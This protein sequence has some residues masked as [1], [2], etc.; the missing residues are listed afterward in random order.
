ACGVRPSGSWMQSFVDRCEELLGEMSPRELAGLPV[1]LARL[2]AHPGRS[3]LG[4]YLDV[5][6]EREAEFSQA[7]VSEAVRAVASLDRPFLLAW[8]Q[9]AMLRRQEQERERQQQQQQARA[10]AAAAAAAEGTEAAHAGKHQQQH[11]QQQLE[12]EEEQQEEPQQRSPAA[13]DALASVD[14]MLSLPYDNYAV[15]ESGGDVVQSEE[16][17]DVVPVLPP[18]HPKQLSMEESAQKTPDQPG[19]GDQGSS[20][21]RNSSSLP[22]LQPSPSAV[23]AVRPIELEVDSPSD[24][25]EEELRKAGSHNS[26]PEGASKASAAP[27]SVT[28]ALSSSSSSAPASSRQLPGS[29][30]IDGYY[31]PTSYDEYGYLYGDEDEAEEEEQAE[32][33]VEA[34][35]SPVV[36]E[37][38]EEQQQVEESADKEEDA[39]A[40][41]NTVEAEAQAEVEVGQQEEDEGSREEE[42]GEGGNN[43]DV[44]HQQQQQQGAERQPLLSAEE[45]ARARAL[46]S[47]LLERYEAVEEA[48]REH[49]QLQALQKLQQEQQ[50]K[51]KRRR[52]F[53]GPSPSKEKE[54][55]KEEEAVAVAEAKLRAAREQLQRLQS[56]F[57]NFKRR[58]QTEREQATARAKADVLKPLLGIADNFA[59]AATQIK[60][61]SGGERA[62]HEAYQAIN[63]QLTQLLREQ[64]LEEV[65]EEG[66]MF[67]PNLHE[68]VMREDRDDV[69]DGTVTCVFQKGY[70]IGELLIRPA[71][72]KVAYR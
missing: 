62:V 64:G 37:E 31:S 45:L 26:S 56:D 47:L 61:K 50:Q 35:V 14:E 10:A 4:T 32:A 33:E 51:Q 55:E 12:R 71:L 54:Q 9:A 70:R 16:A 49:Q 5:L 39:Q 40:E 68:A 38:E 46:R 18:M 8:R 63:A 42:E 22:P 36:E 24:E 7:E 67:D 41:P 44:T 2:G 34:V 60:P 11:H 30:S 20:D 25:E 52:W 69:E 19:S 43:V 57:A 6:Q 58:A 65:G 28:S 59:R 23:A 1:S 27:E 66:E 53:A 3:W 15:F 17:G 21:Q 29:Y 13:A 48:V 72:V